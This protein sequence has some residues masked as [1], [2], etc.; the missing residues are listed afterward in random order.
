VE[1]GRR[2]VEEALHK[3]DEIRSGLD[4]DLIEGPI[5]EVIAANSEVYV[6]KT[7]TIID[8]RTQYD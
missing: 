8:L 5:V 3:V 6:P 7:R 4:N 1:E 2:G